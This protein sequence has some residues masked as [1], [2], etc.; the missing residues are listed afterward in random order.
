V[1]IGVCWLF[2]VTI[3]LVRNVKQLKQKR[4]ELINSARFIV[5]SSGKSSSSRPKKR[6]TG[7]VATSSSVANG[8]NG[9]RVVF[10]FGARFFLLLKYFFYVCLMDGCASL[11]KNQN[12]E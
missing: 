3:F 10:V 2:A 7:S 9:G 6:K 11:F 8:K 12:F 1:F 5:G 4:I